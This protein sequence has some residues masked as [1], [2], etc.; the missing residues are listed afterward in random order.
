LVDILLEVIKYVEA[1]IRTE[2]CTKMG[3]DVNWSPEVSEKLPEL[4][5]CIGLI[6][7]VT[8]RKE[9]EQLR[10]LKKIL[11]EEVRNKYNITDLKDDS[12]VRDYRDFYW[13]LGID[14]TKTR[15]A[16]EA[17]VRR[18]LCGDELPNVSTVVDAY[19]LA[20]VKTMVPM[21][22][23]NRDCIAPPFQVRFARND[24]AFTGI[25]MKAPMSLKENMLV[26]TDKKQVLCIYPY[27]DSDK[28]KITLETTNATIV[29]YGAPGILQNRLRE[30]VA[31][32]LS[33]IK[34]SSRGEIESIEVFQNSSV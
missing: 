28:T 18:V 22:G 20:S 15:P 26:L 14:P 19:N 1:K 3:I 12:T 25:G 8:A 7:G 16:G 11:Y 13:K 5:I 4:A 23:F 30:A 2:W 21:S 6:N 17:L 34:Q 31:T 29:G 32:A 27:R 10:Q 33:L 9:N 24:E